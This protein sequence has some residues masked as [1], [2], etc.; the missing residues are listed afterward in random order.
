[1]LDDVVNEKYV[2]DRSEILTRGD[3]GRD[4]DRI[5]TDIPKCPGI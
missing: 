4:I 3:V 5:F 2:V 1:M